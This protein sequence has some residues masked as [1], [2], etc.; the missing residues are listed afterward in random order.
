MEKWAMSVSKSYKLQMSLLQRWQR[1][2]CHSNQ[3][4]TLLE[5][6]MAIVIVTITVAMITPPIFLAVATRLQNQRAERAMQLAQSEIDRIQ[7]IV[8]RGNYVNTALPPKS[9]ATKLADTTA[10]TG[11]TTD[12]SAVSVTQGFAVDID[13]G[14]PDYVIQAFRDA[15]QAS[16]TSTA[17][18]PPLLAF[19]M[20]VRVY[21]IRAFESPSGALQ[22]EPAPLK[23]TSGEGFQRQRPLAVVYTNVTRSD[24]KDSFDAYRNYLQ[25]PSP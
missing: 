20:G 1:T 5:C 9:T 24:L 11:Y 19:Q 12:R 22:T 15:G 8:T 14:G 23:F 4:L 7:L 10:P 13:G 3:G 18:D 17:T 6:I 25:P 16:P 2:K 21:S